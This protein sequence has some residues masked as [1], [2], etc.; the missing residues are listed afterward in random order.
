MR[1][2]N[3]QGARVPLSRPSRARQKHKAGLHIVLAGMQRVEIGNA[4]NAEH[5]GLTVDDEL[6]A[7]VL[8]RG[9][10]DPGKSSNMD[11]K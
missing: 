10:D 1:P 6:L 7:P 11:R 3:D 5:H 2:S 8:Q 4:V 9:L